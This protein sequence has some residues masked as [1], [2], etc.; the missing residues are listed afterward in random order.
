MK[1]AHS[2]HSDVGQLARDVIDAIGREDQRALGALLHD[3]VVWR[4][5][6]GTV[7]PTCMEGKRAVGAGFAP[8]FERKGSPLVFDELRIHEAGDC[9]IVEFRNHAT[10]KDGRLYEGEGVVVVESRGGKVAEIREYLNP[11]LFNRAVN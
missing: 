8:W 1:P 2:A 7:L 4:I 9:A 6:E 3:D 11:L 10:M 5:S